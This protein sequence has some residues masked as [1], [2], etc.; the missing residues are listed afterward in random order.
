MELSLLETNT[1][2]RIYIFLYYEFPLA[3]RTN[4]CPKRSQTL[5]ISKSPTHHSPETNV[6]NY[7]NLCPLW[8]GNFLFTLSVGAIITIFS[9][10]MHFTNNIQGKIR[11]TDQQTNDQT[12]NPRTEQ[13]TK[14]SNRPFCNNRIFS[15][16]LRRGSF[17]LPTSTNNISKYQGIITF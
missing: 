2:I 1:D 11:T 15:S 9:G 14:Q 7:Q 13:P 4:K 6:Y 17:I 3:K 12:S 10:T 16:R 5:S 8:A